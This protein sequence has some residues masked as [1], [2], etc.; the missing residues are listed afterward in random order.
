MI[1]KS[2]SQLHVARRLL[3]YKSKETSL[4]TARCHQP[5]ICPTIP[6]AHAT[7]GTQLEDMPTTFHYII[8][9]CLLTLMISQH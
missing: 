5:P 9:H 2:Q 6:S 1:M 4:Q 3:F 8:H 7:V